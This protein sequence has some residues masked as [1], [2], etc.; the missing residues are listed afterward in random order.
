MQAKPG[1]CPAKRAPPRKTIMTPQEDIA[2]LE[3]RLAK[4]E[5]DC[6]AW[7][8]AGRQEKYLE[9]YFM[10]EALQQQLDEQLRLRQP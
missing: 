7:R 9:A 4:A 3:R 5:A 6:D 10:V 1:A 8:V 2:T